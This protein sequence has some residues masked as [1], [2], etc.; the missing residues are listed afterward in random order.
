[1]KNLIVYTFTGTHH[2]YHCNINGVITGGTSQNTIEK[3]W[4]SMLN[5]VK[6]CKVIMPERVRIIRIDDKGGFEHVFIEKV[7]RILS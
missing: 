3:A 6:W 5:T 2:Q 7:I 1:M 4:E